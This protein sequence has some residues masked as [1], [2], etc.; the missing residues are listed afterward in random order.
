MIGFTPNYMKSCINCKCLKYTKGRDDQ[1][2]SKNKT[3]TLRKC[4]K[5]KDKWTQVRE[6]KTFAMLMPIK[7]MLRRLFQ[8][9]CVYPEQKLLPENKKGDSIMIR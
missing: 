9:T 8:D 2:G 1:I 3:V 6:W 4:A 7:R 5:H